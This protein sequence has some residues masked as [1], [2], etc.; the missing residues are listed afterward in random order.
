MFSGDVKNEMFF[1]SVAN[2][3]GHLSFLFSIFMENH[4]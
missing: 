3:I 1:F 4:C 2:A